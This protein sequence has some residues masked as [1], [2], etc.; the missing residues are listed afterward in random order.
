[1]P[2]R[3]LTA[4]LVLFGLLFVML[5]IAGA[6]PKALAQSTTLV[7]N[8][9]DYDQAS[10]DTAEYIEIKNVSGAPI[11]LDPYVLDFINGSGGGA[12]SYRMVDLP[13]ISLAAGD[14]YVVCANAATVANCDLDSTPETDFIQNGAP[15]A[16]ALM[17]GIDIVDTVSYEGDTSGS[18]TEG[19]GVGLVDTASGVTSIS[20]CS[21]GT[22]TDQNNIDLVER[23]S[24]PGTA[25]DCPAAEAILV[26]NEIDYDQP[27]TD[28]AEFVE[29]KNAGA[30]SVNLDDY[31]VELVNGSGGGAAVYITI[32][33]PAATLAAGDYYVICANAATVPNCDLDSSPEENF[34]QNGAP[35]AVALKL[36]ADIVDTVSYE[37]DTGAPYTEGSGAG[38][39]DPGLEG[40]NYLGISRFPDGAD[41][42][43][44]NVDLSLRCITPGAEN[45][46][47]SSGC[48]DP[49]TGEPVLV[50]N[51]IDYD[52][53]S[54][55]AAEFVEIMNAGPGAVDLDPYSLVLVNGFDASTYDT[56]DLPAVSLA[57]GDYFVVCANA[58]TV[59]NCD[60]DDAPD[61]NFIQNGAP[62]AV[63]LLLGVDVVDTVSYEGDTAAPYT[64][65]SGVGLEDSTVAGI[66]ISRCPDG[67]DTNQNNLDLSQRSI[68][69]GEANQCIDAVTV[70]IYEI[71]GAGDTSP[72]DGQY[73][74][75]TGIVVGD[76]QGSDELNGFFIQDQTGD[77]NTATSDGIFVYDPAGV[78]VA[79]GD[80]VEVTG[81]ATEFFTLTEINSVSS[82]SVTSTGN[83]LPVPVDVTLPETTNG[84]LEQYEGMYVAITDASDMVVAQ[85]FFL[86]RYGQMTLSAGGRLYQPTNQFEPLSPEAI[87]LAEENARRILILDDGQDINGLGDNP[88]PV[89]YIGSPP[90]AVL[91]AGDGVSSLVG[92]LDFG[93]INASS[94]PARDYRLHPT[95]APVFA[96]DNPRTAA[97]DPIDGTLKVVSF[98]VLNYFTT[99]DLGPDIC[100]PSGN[101]ECRGADSASEFT[102]QQDKIVAAMVSIDADIL[103]LIELENN[104][105]ASPSN[106]GTDPV[107]ETLVAALNAVMGPGTYDFIDA[108]VIGT[109]A[110]KQAFIYKP[111]TVT[112]VGSFAILDSS[113]DPTFLDTR[114]RPVL[115]QTFKE[116]ASDEA[117][118]VAVNHLKSKGSSCADIGDPDTGDGQGNCN[119][120]RLSAA[121][122]LVNWLATDPTGSG[123][124]DFL[125]IGD[126]NSY[127]MEDPILAIQ[128]AGYTNLISSFLG[129]GAYSYIFDGL[130][131]YLDHALANASLLP[132]VTGVTDWHINTDEPAVIDYDENFNP[133]GYYSAD[134]YRAA[135]H[136]PVVVGLDFEQPEAPPICT[137]AFASP[138]V[139][140]V[141][142]HNFIKIQVLGVTDPNGDPISIVIDSIFQDEAVDAPNSGGTAPD[143]KGI[144]RSSAGVR[145]ERV[146]GGNGRVYHI[147]FTASDN[148]GGSCSGVV[149]V[150]VRSNRSLPAIDDGP[151]YDSTLIP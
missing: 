143:G 49:N 124:S 16:V 127:A 101:M 120:T 7:I 37:G 57:A 3:K 84:E 133:P 118:T 30:G 79:L 22:D 75:T 36:S 93:R 88:N 107:L 63:A 105:A 90:P 116:N 35:D 17:L 111:A 78:S 109:D 96:P 55:D 52:Q 69:P 103:G 100:G 5:T 42:D 137:A 106:D 68:S 126:L 20:R 58:A 9:I 112:P 33:L 70:A 82:L 32:D 39:E 13:A 1:M 125:I 34:I 102:R 53:D 139:L 65:G 38:L 95:V 121:I 119:L 45:T 148:A 67:A 21:D 136:D 59:L 26:I 23:P 147:S 122:A 151:L 28:T 81:L 4:F 76:F 128:D 29:I 73:V 85:N 60:L 117:F 104:A 24:T 77:G 146:I 54:T 27:F 80:A 98:N 132:Y 99:L 86:G 134:P 44:N 135:D 12:V 50:I 149:K 150:E 114:N 142:N 83:P 113:V 130:S 62:D 64:E 140:L 14:Y 51:E 8:E 46:S 25:N 141:P 144:G 48:S 2:P 61:T 91:R 123:D 66:G 87:A 71:Q 31:S 72:Y 10:T 18:Y 131:G 94:P 97:P 74:T 6:P 115:A 56:I 47:E 19:S 15:D 110:I 108:G 11:D 41:S 145:A 89:P 92:V 43:Q 129:A 40:N 138:S